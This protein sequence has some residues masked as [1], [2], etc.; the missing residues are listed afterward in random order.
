ML[1]NLT[2]FNTLQVYA[3]IVITGSIPQL[4]AEFRKTLSVPRVAGHVNV[5]KIAQIG[6][7]RRIVQDP[8]L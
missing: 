8:R 3:G 6:D 5:W 2:E 4:G 7:A 1:R